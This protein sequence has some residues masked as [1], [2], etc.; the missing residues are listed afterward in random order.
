MEIIF[1]H[2]KY[3]WYLMQLASQLACSASH[4]VTGIL[5]QPAKSLMWITCIDKL[6]HI[7]H[8]LCLKYL[9]TWSGPGQIWSMPRPDSWASPARRWARP[10][11]PAGARPWPA[12]SATPP[13]RPPQPSSQPPGSGPCLLF[14]VSWP[15]M[16]PLEFHN[17][18]IH[19]VLNTQYTENLSTGDY[20]LPSLLSH[21]K[22]L[23][24]GYLNMSP[25][26][27]ACPQNLCQCWPSDIIYVVKHA[28]SR[29]RQLL[30]IVCMSMYSSLY[31]C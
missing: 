20:S 22:D 4:S 23:I 18:D 5:G 3:L 26:W 14:P 27:G 2:Y 25:H 9:S 16:C 28:N 30:Q 13:A 17:F 29:W 19:T 10:R 21:F 24:M 8:W 7:L 15:L 6:S 11:P 12:S 31:Q 1:L